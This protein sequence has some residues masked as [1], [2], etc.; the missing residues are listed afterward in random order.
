MK[1]QINTTDIYERDRVPVCCSLGT[2]VLSTGYRCVVHGVQLCC[3]LGTT[4][5]F[6]EYSFVVHWVQLCCSLG[7]AVLFTGYRCGEVV[8]EALG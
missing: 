6:T 1:A 8:R 5:L 7:T 4:V 3:L 2:A